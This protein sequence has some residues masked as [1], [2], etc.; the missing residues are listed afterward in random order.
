MSIE[1]AFGRKQALAFARRSRPTGRDHSA[2]MEAIDRINQCWAKA[3]WRRAVPCKWE[4]GVCS[5]SAAQ[6]CAPLSWIKYRGRGK[7]NKSTYK[8][9]N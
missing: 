4:P 6:G 1:S 5:K 9:I 2:L 3:P 7:S 8:P